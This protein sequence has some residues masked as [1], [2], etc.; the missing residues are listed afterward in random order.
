[1]PDM[2]PSGLD[3][4]GLWADKHN[5][6]WQ[7][8]ADKF[9]DNMEDVFGIGGLSDVVNVIYSKTR[10]ARGLTPYTFEITS[11]QFSLRPRWLRSRSR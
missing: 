1:M 5:A 3:S 4:S 9:A 7:A 8:V 10:R 6:G 2:D 11:A